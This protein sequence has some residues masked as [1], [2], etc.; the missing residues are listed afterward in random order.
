MVL[1][2][3]VG[4]LV[5][6]SCARM[7]AWLI[8]C[9]CSVGCVRLR[10][11]DRVRIAVAIPFSPLQLLLW[12]FLPR[13]DSEQFAAVFLPPTEFHEWLTASVPV[14]ASV[15]G[16][17]SGQRTVCGG[18]SDSYRVSRV[19]DSQCLYSCVRAWV[20][21]SGGHALGSL[22]TRTWIV[23]HTIGC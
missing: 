23:V 2:L 19:V 13:A 16:G 9:Y 6:S 7:A 4:P 14:H 5:A 12:R 17:R 20:R 22:P 11:H 10:V 18:A 8:G 21:S 1:V 15:L 3:V